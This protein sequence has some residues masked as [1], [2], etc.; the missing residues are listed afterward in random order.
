MKAVRRLISAAV[1]LALSSFPTLLM[2]GVPA[3]PVEFAAAGF[4]VSEAGGVAVITVRRIQLDGDPFTVR[5]STFDR[6][7]RAGE[8]YTA[9]SGTVSFAPYQ[10]NATFSVAIL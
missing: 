9:S 10:T 5:Y 4:S 7:A 2:A 6:E 8:D 3:G 1:S